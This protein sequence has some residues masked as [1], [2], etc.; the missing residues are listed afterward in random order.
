MVVAVEVIVCLETFLDVSEYSRRRFTTKQTASAIILNK[1]T[2]A[3][4]PS[5]AMIL[6]LVG[7]S[8]G[9]VVDIG[10]TVYNTKND[11]DYNAQNFPG[12]RDNQKLTRSNFWRET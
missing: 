6:M 11:S 10:G 5:T 2:K 7:L 4:A 9:L 3:I 12:G 8:L 1:T